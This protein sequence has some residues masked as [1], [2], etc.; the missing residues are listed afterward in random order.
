M[1]PKLKALWSLMAAERNRYL[2]A[3][4]MLASGTM[5]LYLSPLV[6]RAAI[7]GLLEK[8]AP[9]AAPARLVRA[10][11]DHAGVP[12]ALGLA[13]AAMVAITALSGLLI[14]GKGRL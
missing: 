7:D 11:A 1:N 6:V 9:T 14:Y 4:L 3:C 8:E 5:L 2:A 13:G 12:A 10:I